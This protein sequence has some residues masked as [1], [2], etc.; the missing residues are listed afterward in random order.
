GDPTVADLRRQPPG[1]IVLERTR[2][3]EV[4]RERIRREIVAGRYGSLGFTP[5]TQIHGP[6]EIYLRNDLW[7]YFPSPPWPAPNS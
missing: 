1:V 4:I 3:R 7:E 2:E 6:L 5:A